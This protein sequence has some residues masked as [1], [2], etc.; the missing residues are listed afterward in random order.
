MY[1]STMVLLF[2]IMFTFYSYTAYADGSLRFDQNRIVIEHS[3]IISCINC[4]GETIGINMTSESNTNGKS[5]TLTKIPN[6]NNYTS[7]LIKFTTSS[8]SSPFFQTNV[9]Q[10]VTVTANGVTSDTARI[11]SSSGVIFDSTITNFTDY[12]VMKKIIT[13]NSLDCTNYDGDTDGDGICDDWESNSGYPATCPGKGL[14]VRTDSSVIPYYLA[15]DNSNSTKWNMCPSKNKSDLYYEIDWLLGHK[16]SNE[17][18]SAVTDAFA[19]SNYNSKN[20]VEGITFHAQLSDELPHIDQIRWISSKSAPGFDQLKYW[21]YGNLDERGTNPTV[22]P[23]NSNWDSQRSQKA[24]VVHYLLFIHQQ[25]GPANLPKSGMAE[26][27]GNDAIVSLGSFEGMVGTPDTQK[28]TLLHEIGHNINLDHGGNDSISCKPNYISVMNHAFQFNY[29]V[30]NRTIDFSRSQLTELNESHLNEY[31]GIS[32]TN[33]L[34][35]N[36][37]FN[38]KDS[39]TPSVSEH[40]GQAIDWN[41]N[42]SIESDVNADL[43]YNYQLDD[44]PASPDQTITGYQ[45]WDYYTLTLS[46]LGHG[47]NSMEDDLVFPVNRPED[48]TNEN[49]IVNGTGVGN[50]TVIVDNELSAYSFKHLICKEGF[51]NM[52]KPNN[53]F[54][55]CFKE[56]SVEKMIERDWTL[57][58]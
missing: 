10:N 33:P 34:G 54:R 56:A 43:T 30:S 32:T 40:S 17:T 15:C 26:L 57:A 4:T 9:G 31:N 23:S 14:C 25:F 41:R 27:P 36:T 18:I 47:V 21:W 28:G 24:Q 8:S 11:F 35:M 51:E 19:N 12:K 7:G 53:G 42:G 38:G 48:I 13:P 2:L 1:Y 49:D 22:A 29:F 16:P 5:F 46:P 55:A 6:T 3:G 20:G 39:P 37:T 45:D 52:L 44:C 50:I 58:P